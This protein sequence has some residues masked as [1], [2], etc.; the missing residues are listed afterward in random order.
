MTR[1]GSHSQD[2]MAQA[3]DPNDWVLR[4]AEMRT[5]EA[6]GGQGDGRQPAGDGAATGAPAEQPAPQ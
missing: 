3:G 4:A 6:D 1:D 2:R 5:A